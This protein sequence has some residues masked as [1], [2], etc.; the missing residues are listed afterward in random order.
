MNLENENT[1]VLNSF[2]GINETRRTCTD[3]RNRSAACLSSPP[4]RSPFCFLLNLSSFC[5]FHGKRKNFSQIIELYKKK[6]N[7]FFFKYIKSDISILILRI[8]SY[9]RDCHQ[10]I[11]VHN[12]Q[13]KEITTKELNICSFL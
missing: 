7:Y 10:F 8:L 9:Y 2:R 13:L 4:S 12:F 6:K 3:F 5:I 1:T 11:F